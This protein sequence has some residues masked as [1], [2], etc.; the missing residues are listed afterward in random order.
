MNSEI[1]A[2]ILHF[3]LQV[4]IFNLVLVTNNLTWIILRYVITLKFPWI[5]FR[6]GTNLRILRK[7]YGLKFQGNLLIVILRLISASVDLFNF[8]NQLRCSVRLAPVTLR[9]LVV[10]FKLCDVVLSICAAICP[11]EDWDQLLISSLILGKFWSVLIS[12]VYSFVFCDFC[13]TSFIQ[14]SAISVWITIFA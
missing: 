7:C 12:Y 13:S 5:F 10:F 2:L 11:E 14:L 9:P 4:E 3:H 1:R 6:S 8:L